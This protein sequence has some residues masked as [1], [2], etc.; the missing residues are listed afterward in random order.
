LAG[1]PTADLGLDGRDWQVDLLARAL[2]MAVLG[3]LVLAVS[4]RVV[5]LVRNAPRLQRT[6]TRRP[7]LGTVV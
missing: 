1:V 5:R 3:V 4:P 7:A 2:G 6:A